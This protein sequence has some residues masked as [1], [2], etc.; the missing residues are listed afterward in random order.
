MSAAMVSAALMAAN[1]ASAVR[2]TATA[3]SAANAASAPMQVMG[4]A[5]KHQL[6]RPTRQ[7]RLKTECLQ[8]I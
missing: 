7:K 6:W 4:T 3:V 2:V 8:P 1:R 5:T